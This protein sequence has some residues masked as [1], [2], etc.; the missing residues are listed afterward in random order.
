M[1]RIRKKFMTD[2]LLA[3]MCLTRPIGKSYTKLKLRE[4]KLF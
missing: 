3:G 4:V 2:I 1:R